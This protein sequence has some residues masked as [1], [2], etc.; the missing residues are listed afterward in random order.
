ML[1]RLPSGQKL[2]PQELL[3]TL[4]TPRGMTWVA[5]AALALGGGWWYLNDSGPKVAIAGPLAQTAPKPKKS[6]VGATAGASKRTTTDAKPMGSKT[7][8]AKAGVAAKSHAASDEAV[9]PPPASRKKQPKSAE[10][11]DEAS[12][13][14][15]EPAQASAAPA[16]SH[17]AAPKPQPAPAAVAADPLGRIYIDETNGFSI[18]FPAGWALRTF[19]G[20]PW[21]LDCGDIR[22]GLISVGFSPLPADITA[23]QLLPEAI[24]R[25]IKRRPNT[26]LHA[27]GRTTVDG[28]KAIWSKSTGPLPTTTGAPRMTRV[29]YI[30]PLQDG[31]V[32]ELRVAAPPEQFDIVA[33]VMGKS[34]ATFKIVPRTGIEP[35]NS[36]PKH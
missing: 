2:Q 7:A 3:A 20:D 8:G 4:R 16:E 6:I 13:A 33:P 36:P 34:L 5:V 35:L 12:S 25:R 1:S 26:V 11:A 31:R 14:A 18:R 9:A 15:P 21:V 28:K 24:G 17:T 10:S 30:I 22:G 19:G 29:Q 32:L 27:Q 23:E